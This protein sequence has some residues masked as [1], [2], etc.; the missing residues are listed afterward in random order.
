MAVNAATR[1]E[2]WDRLRLRRIADALESV[3][4]EF[5]NPSPKLREGT[6]SFSGSSRILYDVP[7]SGCPISLSYCADKPLTTIACKGYAHVEALVDIAKSGVQAPLSKPLPRQDLYPTNHKSATDR[8]PNKTHGDVWSSTSM[9]SLSGQKFT[10]ARSASWIKVM[11]KGDADPLTTGR[12]I[13][14]LSFPERSSVNDVTDTASI[15]TPE[16]ERCDAVATEIIHQQE[17]YPDAEVLLQAGD[18]NAA[19]RN[20]CTHSESVYLFGGRFLPD[21]ALVIDTSAPFGWS[22]SPANYGVIGGAIAYLHGRSPNAYRTSGP[23]NYY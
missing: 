5:P 1:S 9:S 23:F 10:S 17:S 21:N 18:V 20:V 4:L 2:L 22:G 11:D 7:K 16:Y 12:V 19:F 15:R 14:D 8:Y 13:H 3:G 6:K